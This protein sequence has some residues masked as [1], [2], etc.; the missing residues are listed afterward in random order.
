MDKRIYVTEDAKKH[1]CELFKCSRVTVWNAL[2]F[3]FNSDRAR[4]IRYVALTQL[5]GVAN[6]Q[7]DE[8]ETTHE[9]SDGTMTQTFGKRVK[10]V[11]SLHGGLATVYVDGAQHTQERVNTIPD[12]MR[13]QS[14]VSSM[15]MSL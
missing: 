12:L 13:L 15:A 1:L 4:K 10:L 11:V 3:K 6:W 7:G 2:T 9:T 5:H 8:M 14:R